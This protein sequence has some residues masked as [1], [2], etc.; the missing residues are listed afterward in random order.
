MT[1]VSH[2]DKGNFTTIVDDGL[3]GRTHYF[4]NAAGLVDREIDPT[5]VEKRYE[6]DLHCARWRRSTAWG[7]GRSG[8]ATIA[9]TRRWSGTRWV[10]RFGGRSRAE[11]PEAVVDAT[12]SR[13]LLE[14]DERGKANGDHGSSRIRTASPTT[15]DEGGSKKSENPLRADVL[16]RVRQKARRS[17]RDEGLGGRTRALYVGRPGRLAAYIDPEGRKTTFGWDT[18]DRATEIHFPDGGVERRAYDPE[19]PSLPSA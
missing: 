8:R 11:P 9:G 4:G 1:A 17:R 7:T 15:T 10:R 2:Y 16:A 13:W 5:G 6:W 3:G 19:T 14:Y 12:G 18:R